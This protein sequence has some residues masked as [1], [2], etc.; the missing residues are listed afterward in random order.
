MMEGVHCQ[1]L[2]GLSTLN[3]QPFPWKNLQD[4][5]NMSDT[6]VHVIQKEKR[7]VQN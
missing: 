3:M 6:A 2:V 5:Q 1:K 4:I 7:G